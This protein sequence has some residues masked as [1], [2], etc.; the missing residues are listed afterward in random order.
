MCIPSWGLPPTHCRASDQEWTKLDR[1]HCEQ[2]P[3]P[4]QREQRSH[5][6]K[7]SPA[8]AYIKCFRLG[9]STA[10]TYSILHITLGFSQYFS[11]P[12]FHQQTE[13]NP[14]GLLFV[15][16]QIFTSLETATSPLM[17]GSNRNDVFDCLSSVPSWICLSSGQVDTSVPKASTAVTPQ[18][19]DRLSPEWASYFSITSGL[20]GRH[21]RA[22]APSEV[23]SPN[24]IGLDSSW[25]PFPV[26]FALIHTSP[27][28]FPQVSWI[29]LQKETSME[30]TPFFRCWK[31]KTSLGKSIC[32]VGDKIH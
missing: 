4:R 6:P 2:K 16:R 10:G 24:G 21:L 19:G 9:P 27:S 12:D 31:R 26:L 30:P 18:E 1:Q 14:S 5:F 32:L 13:K 17:Q 7:G 29:Q 20:L 3:R 28:C 8:S 11:R 15:C 22:Q 25:L 23:P